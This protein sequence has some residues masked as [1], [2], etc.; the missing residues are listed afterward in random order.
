MPELSN[1]H[2]LVVGIAAYQNIGA[3]PPTV[4]KD[5]QDMYDLLVSPAHCAYPT[6]NVQL[7]LDEQATKPALT[8]A[9]TQLASRAAAGATVLI[10]F[11]GHGAR[12][13]RAGLAQQFLLPVEANT[14][15][16]NSLMQT[17]ISGDELTELFNAISAERLVIVFDACHAGGLG[18][19]KSAEQLPAKGGLGENLY[20][21]LKQGRGRVIF[22]SSRDTEESWVLPG[23]TNSLFSHHLLAGLRGGAPGPG[24]VVRVFDLFDYLQP[25]VTGDQPKQHPVFK[26]EIET[27]FPLALFQGGQAPAPVPP[28]PAADDG[29]QF[30][31]YISYADKKE[32]DKT[33]VRKTLVPKLKAAGL[34]VATDQTFRLGAPVI[35]EIERL[36]QVSRYT[37]AILTPAY[38]SSGFADLQGIL[39][40]HLGIEQQQV[41]LL[42]ALRAA[43]E[44]RL[45]IRATNMLELIDD[46][47]VDSEIERL[48]YS[49]RE[50]VP[51]E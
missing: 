22:A 21:A 20:E 49:I 16:L 29:Y 32:P 35:K 47:E 17:A 33:W 42:A 45:S 8:A 19:T 38:L 43:C 14:T 5:A 34:R 27:N 15:S 25:K 28:L 23:A 2:A 46:D 4:R 3:L 37:L 6:D 31:V 40:Q 51:A 39:A 36:V 26:A 12:F 13:E 18:A 44:P 11:S 9:F 7:L 10:F 30:D 50:A 24:G 48:V 41:R 1:A